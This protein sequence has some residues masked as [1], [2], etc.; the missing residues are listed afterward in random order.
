LNFYPRDVTDLLAQDYGDQR[1]E[2]GMAAIRRGVYSKKLF[3]K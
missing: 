2:L 1:W 3:H